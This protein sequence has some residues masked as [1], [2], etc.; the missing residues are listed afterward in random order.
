VGL[1]DKLEDVVTKLKN[2]NKNNFEIILATH[3]ST[4]F[5]TKKRYN[6]FDYYLVINKALPDKEQLNKIENDYF[7]YLISDP[8]ITKTNY[9]LIQLSKKF[10][11]K[12]L[13][14]TDVL[15]NEDQRRCYLITP[16]GDKIYKDYD[17]FTISGAKFISK[18]LGIVIKDLFN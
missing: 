17:H 11:L 1:I 18:R 15:C 5:F 16:D 12:I 9:H 14:K 3:H 6:I 8:Q 7:N 2:N 13:N 4:P 10:N